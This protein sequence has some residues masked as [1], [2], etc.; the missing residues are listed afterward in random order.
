MQSNA[1]K[2]RILVVEN[3][4]EDRDI[5]ARQALKPLG[6]QVKTAELVSTGI[7]LALTFNPDIIITNSNLPDLSGKDLLV[8]LNAQNIRIPVIIVADKGQEN[9]VITAFR[10]GASDFI[11]KPLREAEV[12]AIVERAMETVR[13]RKE[14]ERLAKKL[15]AANEELNRRVRELTTIFSLGKAVTSITDQQDLFQTIVEGAVRITESQRGYLLTRNAQKKFILS[16]HLNLPRSLAHYLNR[17]LDDG[18]SSLVALSGEPLT[19]N[20]PPLKRFNIAQL[21]Q[22]AMVVP[23][24]AQNET[25]GL[26]VTIR[27][28]NTPYK[29]SE[30]D[31]LAAVADYA[32]IS[33]VNAG[34]FK[35]LEE[36]AIKLQ[37]ALNEASKIEQA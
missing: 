2:E 37:Q 8:A 6:Y 24:K 4:L 22:S 21:G 3:S 20:G 25:V 19:I 23:V 27:K 14:R 11:S 31:L 15:A 18:I 12:V 36:R 7:Q 33:M 28:E 34:L 13:A 35:A 29:T 9:D 30:M 10:L 1:S 5:I 17:Q 26:L 32:A 16:A